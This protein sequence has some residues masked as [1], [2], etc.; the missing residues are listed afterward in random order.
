LSLAIEVCKGLHKALCECRE[1]E[2]NKMRVCKTRLKTKK[3]ED[4]PVAANLELHDKQAQT[5]DVA[6]TL[7]IDDVETVEALRAITQRGT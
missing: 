1:K 5:A 7:K 3:V 2:L 6:A 4:D